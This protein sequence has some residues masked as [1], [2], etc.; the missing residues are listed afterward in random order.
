MLHI[1]YNKKSYQFPLIQS[2]DWDT[3]CIY[4]SIDLDENWRELNY[5]N[6]GHSLDINAITYFEIPQKYF[7]DLYHEDFIYADLIDEVV[8][9]ES[10]L[11]EKPILSFSL[12]ICFSNIINFTTYQSVLIGNIK[13]NFPTFEELQYTTLDTTIC[14]ASLL[15][16][17]CYFNPRLDITQ[18]RIGALKNQVLDLSCTATF[19]MGDKIGM[20]EVNLSL[21]VFLSFRIPGYTNQFTSLSIPERFEEIKSCFSSIYDTSAY[22]TEERIINKTDKQVE[23]RFISR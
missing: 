3:S 7:Q 20:I 1:I 22:T 16:L 19:K 2:S 11:T 5:K 9:E 12:E 4:G 8:E 13:R 10:V 15:Q 17:G 23:V 21:P 6:G 14:K 18:I